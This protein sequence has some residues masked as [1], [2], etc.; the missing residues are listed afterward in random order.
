[1]RTERASMP[2]EI[3]IGFGHIRYAGAVLCFGN[4]CN[5][6]H[7]LLTSIEIFE[8]IGNQMG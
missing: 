6:F 3:E 8:L 5:S 4:D 1:M 7:D 2:T